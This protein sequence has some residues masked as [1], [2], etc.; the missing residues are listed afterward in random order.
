LLGDDAQ[1]LQDS[2]EH[3]LFS[4]GPDSEGEGDS[5]NRGVHGNQTR[6]PE[7]G[8]AWDQT[9]IQRT[10]GGLNL[11]EDTRSVMRES[12]DVERLWDEEHH[13]RTG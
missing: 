1:C 9:R 10:N 6:R 13:T 2:V 3:T 11:A 12:M 8:R 5:G 7:E 4:A